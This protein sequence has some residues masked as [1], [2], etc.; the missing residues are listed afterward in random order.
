V[1][2]S[3][4]GWRAVGWHQLDKHCRPIELRF[5]EN[6]RGHR[7]RHGFKNARRYRGIEL[8][9]SFSGIGG[10]VGRSTSAMSLGSPVSA[11]SGTAGPLSSWS[12][13]AHLTGRRRRL[14]ER[15]SDGQAPRAADGFVEPLLLS[16]C[17]VEGYLC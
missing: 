10:T 12:A 6:L 4:N 5:V 16:I 11:L 13:I 2:T 15:L 1:K 8:V 17:M 3:K 7:D 14:G 9:E